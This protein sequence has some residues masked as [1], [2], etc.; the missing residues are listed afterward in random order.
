MYHQAGKCQMKEAG[1]G[2]VGTS[3]E[4][5]HL[6]K[7][8]LFLRVCGSTSECNV[9]LLVCVFTV[10]ESEDSHFPAIL[11]GKGKT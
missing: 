10:K 7:C 6:W 9:V 8:G 5:C 1:E 3:G 2:Q 11:E 4:R